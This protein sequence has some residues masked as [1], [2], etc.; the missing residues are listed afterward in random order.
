MAYNITIDEATTGISVANTVQTIEIQEVVNNVA[1]TNTITELTVSNPSYPITISY[2]AVELDGVSATIA[3]GTVTTG[4]AGSSAAI[5]NSGTS[6]AAVFDFTIP[7]GDVGATGA[8]GP[9]GATGSTGSTGATGTAAT[10]AAGTTTTGSA[11]SSASVTNSGTSSAAVFDFTVP[12][13]DTGATGATGSTGATGAQGNR[14]GVP[15]TFSTATTDS[16]MAGGVFKFNNATLASV[17]EIYI[18]NNASGGVDQ[19]AWID[20]WD[21]STT[22]NKG[23]LFVQ[24]ALVS[25]YQLATF[26]VTG[27]TAASGYYKIAVSSP[28]GSFGSMNNV[29]CVISFSPTGDKGDTGT[30]GATGSTGATGPGVAVGGTTGQVLAKIDGTNYN[31]Q[32]VTPTVDTNTTYTQNA[33]TVA[34]GANLNLVGSDSTTD[35][36]KFA[37]GTGITV[38]RTDADTITITNTVVGDVVGPA[39]A[40]DNAVARFDLTTGKLIQN[41]TVTIDDSG[42]IISNGLTLTTPLAVSSGGTGR[43]VGNYSI[44]ANEIHVGKDGNDTT[45][46]G[47]LINPVL[48][49]TKALTLIG[50]GRN[51]V[52]VH[53][54]SYSESPTVSS[55]NTTIATA[56]LTG[57]NTQISGTLTLS[58]AARVSGIKLTNL[59]ITG[60]GNAYISNCTVDTQV[61]KS[62]SNYVEI[63]NSELQC[64]SGIQITGAGT[65]SIV[66]NKC[67]AV[68]VSNASANVL[69]KD[70][71]QVITPSVTAGTLQIDGSAI[72]AASPS[73]NAVTSS[74]SSFITLA[75]SFVLNSAGTNVERVSLSGFYSILNLVY[76]KPN[77]TLIATSGTGGNLN[78]IDYFSVVNADTVAGTSGLT[79]STVGSNGNITLAPNGT[80]NVAVNGKMLIT[81]AAIEAFKIVSSTNLITASAFDHN[82]IFDNGAQNGSLTLS[83]S[84][85]AIGGNAG[86]IL[87]GPTSAGDITVA[88]GLSGNINLDADTIR[89]GDAAATATI[90]SNGAGNLVLNTNAGTNAGSITFANGTNGNITVAPNGTGL[91]LV[92][93][94]HIG[95][96]TPASGSSPITGR[97]QATTSGTTGNYSLMAQKNRTDILLAAMTSEPAVIGFEVRDSAAV[98]RAF[99]RVNATYQGTASNPFFLF[100]SSVDD[101]TTTLQHLN[102]GAGVGIFGSA[103]SAYTLTTNGTANLTLSTN[104]GTNSGTIVIANGAGGNITLTPDTTGDVVLSAD[105]VVVGDSAATATITSNGAGNLVLNTN[106]GTNA[107]SITLTQ[108]TNGDIVIEPNGTGDVHL[109]T[110]ALRIGDLN[111]EARISTYGTGDLVLTTNEGNDPDPSI[112]IGNG[113]NANITIAPTGTGKTAATNLTYNEGVYTAGTTTGTITPNCANGPV[114]TITLTG[115]IT[116]SAFT[117]PISGQT[118][119]LIITQ[120]ATG[121]PYTL[122]ST[123]LFAGASKTLSTAA[124]AVDI[125]TVSYIGTTYYASLSKGFA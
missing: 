25:G 114:Q 35:T 33:S 121:G 22:T 57:A 64:V 84:G 26:N 5:T 17:T 122:T 116:F 65:V 108:G 68:A 87:I 110:D 120:P 93:G 61:I 92:T 95:V 19:V 47:T 73:S 21:D 85:F 80:G 72:F 63:I 7:R 6:G 45:G 75:N 91:L 9:T 27:I 16:L 18:S 32:W 123:M 100:Q 51:T 96:I 117:S 71:F 13:G 106:S 78:A 77:S 86:S 4:A 74:A 23:K 83:A 70:C 98:R 115:S 14:G 105:T 62:G 8:T 124:N 28:A 43:A 125:L 119:T 82:L 113:A 38:T 76:D 40:T 15:W 58:A 11:G 94:L 66:G 55:A 54:G 1:V 101:F 2:N 118:L 36:I 31:T 50:A 56:E 12:R 52:I 97:H 20:S 53:P 49:I 79:L 60:S 89:V 67:W 30:T 41:S 90:T 59:T 39:S 81:S 29:L 69:I 46:D 109:V 102:L 44:Y 37:S 103:N 3:V 107:G 112:T 34:G 88:P 104:S 42:N 48:T 24:N 99:A 111:A 10:I